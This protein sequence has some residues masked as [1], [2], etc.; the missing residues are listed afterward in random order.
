MPAPQKQTIFISHSS[1]NKIVTDEL[2]KALT[3]Q[4]HLDCWMDNF[5]LHISLGTFSAQ[6]VDALRS[7]KLMVQVDS[8][9]ARASDYVKR[10]IQAAK[11]L[12]IPVL[13]CSIDE[14]QPAWL[15]KIKIQWLAWNIQARLA[16]GFMFAALTLFL[17]LAAL[18][19]GIFFLGTRV[20]PALANANLRDLPA[21]FQ[22]T[23]TSTAIPTPSDPKIAAPFHFNPDI[24]LLQDDFID[25]GFENT[26]NKQTFDYDIVPRDSQVEVRQQDGRLIIYFPVDCLS[27]DKR[28]DCELELD[29]RVLDASAI[30]YFGFRART[31]DRTSMRSVS[32]SM[33]ISDPNRSRA[34]FGWNFTEHAMAYFRSIPALPE[35]ELYAYVSMDLGWHAYEI[36]RDPQDFTFYY[37]IDG[38][39]VDT[40]TPVN[41]REWEQAPLRLIIY[42]LNGWNVS[43]GAETSTQFEIEELVVGGFNQ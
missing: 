25:P 10:E 41:A 4:F 39:L 18:A 29:S 15:R 26:F 12:Q 19:A 27:I 30:Q 32:V 43:G 7:S 13:R 3:S 6:I 40:F 37:Y 17:L 14:Q 35:K 2:Y 33:S 20:I 28:W 34:G 16:R 8:S 5:D 21:A 1:L 23:P 22:P 36:L 42:S 11:D 9:A 38:Q 24:I 31:T